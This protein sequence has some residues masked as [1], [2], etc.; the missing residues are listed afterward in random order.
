MRELPA[1]LFV[2]TNNAG[3]SQMAGP[4]FA[5]LADGQAAV[6]TA[7]VDPWDAPHPMAVRLM[8]EQGIDISSHRPKHVRSLAD[9]HFDVV[10]TIGDPARRGLP[11]RMKG[12]PF[13]QHWHIA[14]PA[15]ADYTDASEIAFRRTLQAIRDRLPDLLA[16]VESLRP[17][18]KREWAPGISTLLWYPAP[19]D[20]ARHAPL[21][22]RFGFEAI[23]LCLYHGRDAFDYED[24][25]LMAELRRVLDAEGL[26]LWSIH[27]PK[28]TGDL[29]SPET[30]ERQAAIDSLSRCLDVADTLGARVV[31]SH[32]LDQPAAAKGADGYCAESLARLAPIAERSLA[33]IGFENLQSVRPD[34]SV[35]RVGTRV[36]GLSP[37]AFGCVL[38]TG[39]AHLAGELGAVADAW[40]ERLISVHLHDT[41][42]T[43]DSHDAPTHGVIDWDA[44]R[45]TLH[46][47]GYRGCL[48]YENDQLPGG[49]RDPQAVLAATMAAHQ[50]LFER[51]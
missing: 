19:F 38:D 20:P 40:N 12:D 42:G 11:L 49:V 28:P 33:R 2:C 3:R 29:G 6:D 36:R 43:R 34:S 15:D 21:A 8:D 1:V 44:V 45:T 24:E 10:V 47:T 25:G 32:A 26:V 23:E 27:A 37:A 16:R 4:L 14:D 48:M 7:G 50:R 51:D 13:R 39:H 17:N 18:L 35:A 9:R 41:D 22:A 5:R 46:Q 30:P 31:V